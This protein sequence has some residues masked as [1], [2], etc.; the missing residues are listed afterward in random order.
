MS[1]QKLN[2][3]LQSGINQMRLLCSNVFALTK[4]KLLLSKRS[5]A[6]GMFYENCIFEDFHP[7]FDNR[8]RL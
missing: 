1:N 5:D 8:R 6:N 2:H 4:H 7:E 3:F